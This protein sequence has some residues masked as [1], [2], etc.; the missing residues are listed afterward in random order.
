M[1]FVL[2]CVVSGLVVAASA[3]PARAQE[4]FRVGQV[5]IVGNTE[6]PERI[7]RAPLELYPGNLASRADVRQ[8]EARL[9]QLPWFRAGATVRLLDPEGGREYLDILVHVQE[10]EWNGLRMCAA[11]AIRFRCTGDLDALDYLQHK[12]GELIRGR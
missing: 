4:R 1:R 3:T 10:R 7:I 12:V 11:E 6:T 8:A 2:G 9:R 5:I